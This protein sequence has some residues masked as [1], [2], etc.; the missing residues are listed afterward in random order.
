MKAPPLLFTLA[1][2]V[3]A[4]AVWW[5]MD[6]Q[7]ASAPD[8]ATDTAPDAPA[9]A[10][11]SEAALQGT[12]DARDDAPKPPSRVDRLVTQAT[13][14]DST[15]RHEAFRALKAAYEAGKV[16][17]ERLVR[18]ALGQE[19]AGN[20]ELKAWAIQE[21]AR[22]KPDSLALVPKVLE[23]AL[24][25]TE[26]AQNAAAE[27]VRALGEVR[28]ED[29]PLVQ[30]IFE[31][32]QS[33]YWIERVL[34]DAM[35]ELGPA[36]LPLAPVLMD[37]VTELL[38]DRAKSQREAMEAGISVSW[39]H[40]EY[41]V[42]R[43]LGK[44]GE[45]VIPLLI[46][47]L[48]KAFARPKGDTDDLTMWE[49]EGVYADALI[50][51]GERGIQALIALL[52]RAPKDDRSTIV[53]A[54]TWADGPNETI[55]QALLGLLTSDDDWTRREAAEGL[56]K[57]GKAS[58]PALLEALGDANAGV[59][60]YAA[61][62][63][64]KLGVGPEDALTSLRAMLDGD[65]KWAALTA[66]ETIAGFGRA[67]LP[68]LPRI[69]ELL[70]ASDGYLHEQYA[71]H[72]AVL[73][74]H[75]PG[76]LAAA[77]EAGSAPLQ[78]GLVEAACVM[79]RPLPAPIQQLLV[80]AL[81]SADARTQII[82]A[83]YLMGQGHEGALGPLLRGFD[84]KDGYVRTMATHGLAHAGAAAAHLLPRMLERL[85]RT[86][87]Y[88]ARGPG[89]DG[90]SEESAL[91]RAIEALGRYDFER[92][93]ELIDHAEFDVYYAA[94][95]A[96]TAAGPEGL[97]WLLPRWDGAAQARK[98]AMLEICSTA[99]YRKGAEGEAWKAAARPIAR[100]ALA[101]ASAA[102]R[103][104]AVDKLVRD[105]TMV[106]EVLPVVLKLLDGPSKDIAHGAGYRLRSLGAKAAPIEAELRALKQHPDETV[107]RYVLQT[108]DAI[109]DAAKASKDG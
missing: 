38:V 91:D 59:R 12:A 13:D 5:F 30:K 42:E 58:I 79:N 81:S 1:L 3:A 53:N 34:I 52:D 44:M 108:L 43:L 56:G 20:G 31:H 103:A 85:E 106:A 4:G 93:F 68:A 9:D 83:E 15:K 48:E 80:A 19:A 41:D 21:L 69:L 92:M 39:D 60:K 77:Y 105:P 97:R 87:L 26:A 27:V 67:G 74:A 72:V 66:A 14:R 49:P 78:R 82:A 22:R 33:E 76:A 54:L 32:E 11:S 65:D 107:R 57:H 24:G 36:V 8:A 88:S 29:L 63:L 25:G 6:A 104:K 71:Q 99:W 98:L 23:H 47:R 18:W 37:W 100:K 75:D 70:A 96:F 40:V 28:A 90:I 95:E 17:L 7:Q 109:E 89:L 61:Q 35:D 86:D 46:E 101:D 2:M 94:R 16:P 84:S 51:V 64:K 102:V 55:R 62:S 73:G 10:P 45:D 50:R